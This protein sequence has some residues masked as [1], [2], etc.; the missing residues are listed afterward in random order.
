MFQLQRCVHKASFRQ[1]SKVD[2]W[3]AEQLH[4]KEEG[5]P[6]AHNNVGCAK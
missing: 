1:I 5:N 6:L 2:N 3:S 4:I